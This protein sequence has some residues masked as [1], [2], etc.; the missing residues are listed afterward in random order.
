MCYRTMCDT[1]ADCIMIVH[2]PEAFDQGDVHRLMDQLEPNLLIVAG[3]MGRTAAEESG[4][5]FLHHPHPPSTI[6]GAIDARENPFLVNRGK[7]PESGRIFGEIIAGRLDHARGLVQLECSSGTVYRWND[8]SAAFAARLSETT[9]FSVV[10]ARTPDASAS[11]KRVIRGC[12]PGEAV[13][14][15]G[16]VIGEATGPTVVVES[17]D[18]DIR[19]VSG[20]RVKEHG[21]EKLM[22]QGPIDVTRAW[23]KSGPVRRKQPLMR[24]RTTHT[25]RIRVV[26]HA[27]IELYREAHEG[28]CGVLS[29][30]D[31]TTAVC[32]HICAH[33]GIP[34]FG[35]VDGDADGIVDPVYPPGSVVVEV[36]DGRD[37][38]LGAALALELDDAPRHWD[39]WVREQ[40]DR[41]GTT[42]RIVVDTTGST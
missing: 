12:C 36:I 17:G 40:L 22:R 4:I 33:L 29:I 15:N 6:L 19:A 31:D 18:G 39:L 14:V 26:D 24:T 32:G 21:I 27:G 25:G 7:N 30:G 10:H 2:G 9:G 35:V 38:D 37:D 3:V 42:V 13:F 8:G 1:M 20:L 34:V 41:L 23:C 28:V 16:V 5:P 11:S